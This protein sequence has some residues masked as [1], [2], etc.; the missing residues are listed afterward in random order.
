M[1]VCVWQ[2]PEHHAVNIIECSK[3]FIQIVE[4][5][6]VIIFNGLEWEHTRKAIKWLEKP[7][8]TTNH[9]LALLLFFSS[10]QNTAQR[11]WKSLFSEQIEST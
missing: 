9:L 2:A 7:S 8:D 1:G 3:N 10:F 6:Y 11:N 5:A 4:F